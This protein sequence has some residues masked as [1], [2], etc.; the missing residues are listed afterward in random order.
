MEEGIGIC[1]M[2]SP[3]GLEPGAKV[4]EHQTELTFPDGELW[5]PSGL[6]KVNTVVNQYN[7]LELSLEERIK[8]LGGRSDNTEED[9]QTTD[10]VANQQLNDLYHAYSNSPCVGTWLKVDAGL[11]TSSIVRQ[12]VEFL[13]I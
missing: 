9:R 13:A 8:R 1:K 6:F 3:P 2:V 12:V 4:F 7:H 11:S 10:L 5:T